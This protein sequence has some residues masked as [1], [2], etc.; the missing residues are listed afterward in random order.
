MNGT[1]LFSKT[2]LSSRTK[3]FVWRASGQKDNFYLVKDSFSGRN[4]DNAQ[5]CKVKSRLSSSTVT[6]RYP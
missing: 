4:L 3:H 5:D 1:P 6:E 2:E